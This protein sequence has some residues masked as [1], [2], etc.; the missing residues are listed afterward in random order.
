MYKC[1]KMTHFALVAK[2][3]F[4]NMHI[5]TILAF[6]TPS[7]SI[8]QSK[9]EVHGTKQTNIFKVVIGQNVLAKRQILDTI[10]IC[11]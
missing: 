7:G 8:K 10:G 2:T 5:C 6:N 11:I 9:Y 4:Y 3:Y 1:T